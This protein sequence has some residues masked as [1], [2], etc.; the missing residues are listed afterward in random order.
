MKRRTWKVIA[1]KSPPA[2]IE[3]WVPLDCPCGYEAECPASTNAPII[4]VMGMRVVFDSSNY[5]PPDNFLPDSIQCRKCG[6][7]YS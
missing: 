7:I 3:H 2:E 4:C 5:Q 1:W 6:R